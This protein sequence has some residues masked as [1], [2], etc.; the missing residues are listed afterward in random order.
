MKVKVGG[1]MRG[2]VGKIQMK[3]EICAIKMKL[4]VKSPI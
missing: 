3:K 2:R 1:R 4:T